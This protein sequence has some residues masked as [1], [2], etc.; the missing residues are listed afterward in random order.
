MLRKAK[1]HDSKLDSLRSFFRFLKKIN[2]IS[3][4]MNILRYR[5]KLKIAA[6]SNPGPVPIQKQHLQYF[7]KIKHAY[8]FKKGDDGKSIETLAMNL[9]MKC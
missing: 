8:I 7:A 9:K 3:R 5:L 2:T 1:R 4:K 6:A